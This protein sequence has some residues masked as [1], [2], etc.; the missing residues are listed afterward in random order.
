MREHNGHNVAV[1]LCSHY[2]AVAAGSDVRCAVLQCAATVK[3]RLNDDIL[4]RYITVLSMGAQVSGGA[5]VLR[6]GAETA[7]LVWVRP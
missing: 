6:H 4:S 2:T 5:S 7:G 3:L 1:P